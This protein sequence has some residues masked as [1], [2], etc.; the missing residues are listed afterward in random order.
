MH[1]LNQT[2]EALRTINVETLCAG[3]Q[4]SEDNPM[5]GVS[6]RANILHRLGDSLL[7]LPEIF[8]P[9]GRPGLLVGT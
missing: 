3:L 8:G 5:V 2:G 9:T 4:V 7:S 1:Q 6:A